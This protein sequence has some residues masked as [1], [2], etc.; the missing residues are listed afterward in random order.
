M[1]TGYIHQQRFDPI[2]SNRKPHITDLILKFGLFVDVGIMGSKGACTLEVIIIME[3]GGTVPISI[4][5]SEVAQR[6]PPGLSYTPWGLY[7]M[8]SILPIP[9]R[10]K[11]K[12]GTN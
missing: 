5:L 11:L 2:L 10:L 12:G 6:S 3:E 9:P 7:L 8:K 1:S 4:N